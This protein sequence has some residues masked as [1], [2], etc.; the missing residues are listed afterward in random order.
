MPPTSNQKYE[1]TIQFSAHPTKTSAFSSDEHSRLEAA[2]EVI[3]QN[4]GMSN[5]QRYEL[6]GLALWPTE[7]M[8]DQ[9]RQLDAA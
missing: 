2:S 8:L 1:R 3:E 4:P 9:E 7:Q 6:L 5:D